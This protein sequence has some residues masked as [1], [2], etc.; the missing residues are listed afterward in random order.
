LAIGGGMTSLSQEQGKN[1]NS[2]LR[3]LSG[4]MQK[5]ASHFELLPRVLLGE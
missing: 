4:L 1:R 2:S 3:Y 5:A